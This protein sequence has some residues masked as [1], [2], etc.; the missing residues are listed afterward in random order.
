MPTITYGDHHYA[1]RS[2]ETVLECLSRHGVAVPCSCR[3]GVCQ[4]CMMRA[5]IGTPTAIAQEQLKPTLREQGHFLAC[6]C[7]PEGDLTVTLPGSGALPRLKAVIV[8]KERLNDWIV[9]LELQ[10]VEP[11]AYRP[12]QFLNLHRADGLIRS[13][14]IASLAQADNRIELH[15]ERLPDGKMS[16]WIHD[17][18]KTGDALDIEGPHGECY[19]LEG[20][21]AQPLLLIGTGSG[22]APLWGIARDALARGHTGPVHLFHGSRN[23]GKLYLVDEL[24]ALAWQHGNFHYTPCVSGAEVPTGFSAGRANEVAL[25]QHG[26][27]AGFRVYL[28]GHP[29]MVNDTKM[30]AYLAGASLQDILADPFTPSS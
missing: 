7:R 15:I 17:D 28:C 9:R 27:L 21:P 12:G 26:N 18:A 4:T 22:L 14:S 6:V 20:K 13:Y 16:G 24:R 2:D 25:D 10:P 23:A 11:F 3:K 8:N 1:C 19:Y 29:Q 5:V 30:K